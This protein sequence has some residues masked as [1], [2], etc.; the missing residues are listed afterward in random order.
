M[1]N[2]EIQRFDARTQTIV[3]KTFVN[4]VLLGLSLH[5]AILICVLKVLVGC[6]RKCFL[7]ISGCFSIFSFPGINSLSKVWSLPI[8]QD[9]VLSQFSALDNRRRV[10]F[11]NVQCWVQARPMRGAVAYVA[12]YG[13]HMLACGWL[14]SK[15][16]RWHE[17]DGT[18][19]EWA[20]GWILQSVY[21][22]T[23]CSIRC[24]SLA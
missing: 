4:T 12:E 15:L 5:R 3:C 24:S 14:L 18:E 9:C 21:L 6:F 20:C 16:F 7:R 11:L 13:V 17:R 1:I 22:G 8:C 10:Y 2:V 19:S 23:L